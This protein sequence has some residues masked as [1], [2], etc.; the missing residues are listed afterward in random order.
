[1]IPQSFV[2]DLLAR[3][4][5]VEIVG[6]YVK[7][8]KAGANFVGLCPFHNEKSPSFNVS[9]TKQFYYCF[10]CGEHG[11]AVGFLMEYSGLTFPEAVSELAQS[12]GLPVPQEDRRIT[13]EGGAPHSPDSPALTEVLSTAR[14][15]YRQQL[16][17]SPRA[18]AYLQ[19]RGLSGEIAAH[20]GLGYAPEGWKNLANAFENYGDSTLVEAGLVIDRTADETAPGRSGRY[21]RF[22]DRIMFPI[23]N[24][25]GQVV[26][27][28]GRIIDQGEPKY[29]NSP[30]TP[31]FQKGNELYG[32]FEA[33]Q[34]IRGK[35]FAIVVE[36]YMD[37]VALAQLGIAN[38][39]ATL[40]TACTA[41]HVQKLLRQTDRVIFSFDGDAAGRRAAWR[42]LEA[43]LPYAADN[44]TILFLFLPDAHDPDSFIREFGAVAFEQQIEAAWPLST[45]LT[46]EITGANDLK[47]AEGRAKAQFD[48]KPLLQALPAG[49]L[50][51][52]IVRELA[53]LTGTTVE[54][55]SA[56]AGLQLPAAAPAARRQMGKVARSAPAS[57]EVQIMRLLLSFPGLASELDAASR[58]ALT[59]V[60]QPALDALLHECQPGNAAEN[61]Q[62]SSASV[63]EGLLRGSE[64]EFFAELIRQ[65]VGGAEIEHEFARADLQAAVAKLREQQIKV[66]LNRLAASGLDNPGLMARYREL[67]SER[68]RLQ[69]TSRAAGPEIS[70]T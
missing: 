35:G 62:I 55:L 11:T 39:V 50:R 31:V 64:G 61:A 41:V 19:G 43:S 40:G 9:P 65:W 18:I 29:L 60:G 42:A 24:A 5:V 70:P 28:G 58:A 26:G 21:D 17:S 16:R 10:G 14:A 44:K 22:R 66:E 54:E 34:A 20:F 37:V 48:A 13:L 63:S 59:A 23:R 52:Q 6:K 36:G 51:L 15:Y 32:L 38:A 69:Q 53:R 49:G 4:D 33:R 47:T 27:F 7:L 56:Q 8:K 25:K 3:V 2:H 67:T 57:L 46:R 12:A 45:F 68:N 30:E 1:M